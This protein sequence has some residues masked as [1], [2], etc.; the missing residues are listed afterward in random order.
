MTKRLENA[1]AQVTKHLD[2]EIQKT[3]DRVCA[4]VIFVDCNIGELAEAA[5]RYLDNLLALRAELLEAWDEAKRS[6]E[7]PP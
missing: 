3:K 7:D 2:D 1:M 4:A 5:T 6:K